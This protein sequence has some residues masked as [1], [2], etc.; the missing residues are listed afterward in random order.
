[1]YRLKKGFLFNIILTF[2]TKPF[3]MYLNTIELGVKVLLKVSDVFTIW[4]ELGF[5]LLTYCAHEYESPAFHV[6]W[7]HSV[8]PKISKYLPC[9]AGLQHLWYLALHLSLNLVELALH[10]SLNLIELALHL[11][12]N[13]VELALHLSLNLVE[14]ALHLS[15]N[16]VELALA[17]VSQPGRTGSSPVS[18][19]G[20]TGS[21]P[22]SQPGRTGSSP[23]SQPGRTDSFT[24]PCLSTW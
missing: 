21:S 22:V 19:P 7:E 3:F 4:S 13:L 5:K 23:V 16:L 6:S 10:L 24:C 12:L 15:L 14:L 17:H 20:R 8:V 18:Q 11:S 2:L 9:L 1:M